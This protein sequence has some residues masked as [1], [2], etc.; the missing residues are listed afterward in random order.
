M[1]GKQ[2]GIKMSR[3]KELETVINIVKRA[4]GKGIMSEEGHARLV[5]LMKDFYTIDLQQQAE[6]LAG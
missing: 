4:K 2:G 1:K 3:Q 5:D 6:T